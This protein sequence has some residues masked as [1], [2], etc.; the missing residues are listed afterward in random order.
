MGEVIR[1]PDRPKSAR[2]A[3]FA[4]E[5]DDAASQKSERMENAIA[6]LTKAKIS[7]FRPTEIQL[8]I[9]DDLSFY[10]GSGTINFDNQPRLKERGLYGLRE[11]LQI[12]LGRQL[13]PIR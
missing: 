12:E 1:F 13:P 2:T 8:K 3:Y 6:W 10:P 5:G 9:L 7:F 11:V 4:R